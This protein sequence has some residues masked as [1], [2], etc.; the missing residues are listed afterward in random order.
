MRLGKRDS[1]PAESIDCCPTHGDREPKHG[2]GRD[3][4]RKELKE[5][6]RGKAW[7]LSRCETWRQAQ[8]SCPIAA[9]RVPI[10]GGREACSRTTIL[11]V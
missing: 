9:Q 5:G 3:M 6:W 7:G 1:S 11:D 2:S 8:T 10:G 4:S